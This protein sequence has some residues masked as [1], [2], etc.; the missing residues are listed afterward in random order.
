MAMSMWSVV[1]ASLL[2]CLYSRWF[3]PRCG[4]VY[5]VDGSS[6]A[7]ANVYVVGGSSPVV[8]MSMWSVV[9]INECWYTKETAVTAIQESRGRCLVVNMLDYYYCYI[10]SYDNARLS[11][12]CKTAVNVHRILSSPPFRLQAISR[13][14]YISSN[15]STRTSSARVAQTSER[16]V[17]ASDFQGGP[18]LWHARLSSAF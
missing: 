1:R 13:L 10:Y 11:M 8:A 16:S 3:E 9:R 17:S 12:R 15:N 2:P 7:V 4:H 6:P 14:K 18:F 5:V